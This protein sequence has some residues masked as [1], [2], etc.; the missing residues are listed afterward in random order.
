VRESVRFAAVLRL[1]VSVPAADKDRRVART[2]ERLGLMPFSDVLVKAL[3]ASEKKLLTMA[4][5]LVAEPLVLFLDEP[6]SGLSVSS[7][8]IVVRAMRSVCDSGTGIICT[9][10]QPSQEVFSSFD[11]LLLLRRGGETVY[12]G[13][14]AR[15]PTYF[16]SRGCRAVGADENPADWMLECVADESHDWAAEWNESPERTALDRE[17]ATL[18]VSSGE[19]TLPE[20]RRA[21]VAMQISECVRRQFWRM[22]RMPEYNFARVMLQFCIALLVGIMFLREIDSTQTGANLIAAAVFLSII[23]GNLAVQNVIPPTL[24]T[25]MVYY[26]ELASQTYT[27]VAHHVSIG[28][29]EV[30]F[31]VVGTL[32]FSVVFYFLV[33]LSPSKFPFFLLLNELMVFFTVMLGVALASLSPIADV[34]M[35]LANIWV[36]MFTVLSGFLIRRPSLPAWWRW[37]VWVNPYAYYLS[38]ALRNELVG[39]VFVCS[40]SELGAFAL[41]AEYASCGEIPGAPGGV[42]YA[43][44]AAGDGLCAFCAIPDGET[45]LDDLGATTDKWFAVLAIVVWIAIVRVAAGYG[46]R[47]K[48]FMTR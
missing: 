17:I 3:G 40:A 12:Y 25:R 30:P 20:P 46:F 7:A 27:P 11:R 1:P 37:T 6:T 47:Y 28:V 5:E 31:T 8:M 13:D 38:A 9:I 29:A 44:S 41:P 33:G 23:P 4:L 35:I 10:H 32:V 36:V 19:T 43:A 18:A 34:A 15:L 45:L 22:Y 48:R 26:R 2:L 24:A 21:T 16:S 42:G 39:K 14:V